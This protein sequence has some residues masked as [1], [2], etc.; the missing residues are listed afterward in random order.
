MPQPMLSPSVDSLTMVQSHIGNIGIIQENK[1]SAMHVN[2]GGGEGEAVS[3]Y[4]PKCLF[5]QGAL[6]ALRSSTKTTT[7]TLHISHH[8]LSYT[9]KPTCEISD[10]MAAHVAQGHIQSPHI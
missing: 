1:N 2:G 5:N 10:Q 3:K 9:G 6:T 4:S 8:S 7:T